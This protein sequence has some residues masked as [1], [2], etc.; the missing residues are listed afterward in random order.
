MEGTLP[1]PNTTNDTVYVDFI[2]LP[3]YNNKDYLMVAVYSLSK[4]VVLWECNK[5]MGGET[6]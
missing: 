6:A 5:R 2:A 4:F 3:E 1:I